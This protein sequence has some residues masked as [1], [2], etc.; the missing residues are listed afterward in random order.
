K[1][2]DI[3]QAD[4]GKTSVMLPLEEVLK[5]LPATVL[6][7]RDD[8][9]QAALDK[10]F[11]TPFSIKAREDEARFGAKK[12]EEKAPE[13]TQKAPA[14][15]AKSEPSPAPA[16]E[17][18]DPKEVVTRA[19]A[20][21]GVKACAI[22]FSD[23]LS[24]AGEFPEEVAAEGLCAMAPAIV[25]RVAQHVRETK[26]GALVAV[27][28]HATESAVTYFAHGNICLGVLHATEPLP[29]ATGKEL[30][31]LTEKLSKHYAKTE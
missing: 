29:P 15:D 16:E 21:P 22:T 30:A 7:L 1:H 11:E 13:A 25:E 18:V 26:L 12:P 9:E 14:T 8:Q 4:E 10:D 24:L 20:L 3:F 23:G 2:R 31:G 28:V 19:K 27:T 5:N 17:K 6:K